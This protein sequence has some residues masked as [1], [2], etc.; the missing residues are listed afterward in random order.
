ME[1]KQ[2]VSLYTLVNCCSRVVNKPPVN[3]CIFY[4]M[5]NRLLHIST[6]HVRIHNKLLINIYLLFRICT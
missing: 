5:Y 4:K 6:I 2:P 1:V 3:V